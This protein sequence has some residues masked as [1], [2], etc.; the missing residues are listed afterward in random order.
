MDTKRTRYPAAGNQNFSM[1][2]G[3]G[4]GTFR[5][6]VSLPEHLSAYSMA[7]GDFNND[8][9]LDLAVSDAQSGTVSI[10]LGDGKGGFASEYDYIAGYLPGNILATDLDGDGNLDVVLGSGHPD[11]L[12]A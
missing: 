2:L 11:V 9:K 7:A 5:T 6:A 12:A 4:D 3:N 1:L 10:L 8:G